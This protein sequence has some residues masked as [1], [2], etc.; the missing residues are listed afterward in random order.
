LNG[1]DRMIAA[2]SLE[3]PDR[4][5]HWELAYNESS[6][7]NIA[8]HFTDDLP[9]AGYIQNLDTENKIKLINALLLIIEELDID[10]LTLRVFPTAETISDELFR[11]DWGVTFK[12]SPVGEAAV[13]DGPIKKADDLTHYRP[14]AIQESDLITLIYCAARF[15]GER[16]LVLSMQCPFRRSW[17]MLGGMDNLLYA[18]LENPS[19]VHQLARVATDYTIEALEMGIRLGADI[20]SLDGDLAHNTNLLISPQHFR[21]Y[22][23]P[24]Y[25]E[26]INY[27]HSMGLKVF[28]HTDGNHMKI[29]DDFVEIGFDGIH[30]IQPQCMDLAAI[31]KQY[32]KE[33]CLMGNIDCIETLV[34]KDLPAVE[35]EVKR[36]IE[37]AAPG[38]GYILASSNTIHP[39]VKAENYIGMVKAAHRYGQYDQNGM[40]VTNKV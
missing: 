39:G 20:I 23:K 22:I 11:D 36:A 7:V 25:I 38:G 12:L 3:I 40:P 29:F 5:P 16:A 8:R 26:I 14:P 34:K 9:G 18:Y 15:K 13:I 1:R 31:K 32:G 10:G 17:N 6:V 2:L 28:K 19:L 37:I 30:P 21:E 27:I 33:I 4:V 35:E 24:Y